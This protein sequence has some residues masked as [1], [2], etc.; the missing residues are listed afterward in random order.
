MVLTSGDWTLPPSHYQRCGIYYHHQHDFV[1]FVGFSGR[2]DY[3][4]CEFAIDESY[5]VDLMRPQMFR[6]V[7]CYCIAIKFIA[8]IK[9]Q[10]ILRRHTSGIDLHPHNTHTICVK[11]CF[12][13]VHECIVR[14]SLVF[15]FLS[16]VICIKLGAILMDFIAKCC[17]R[18][19]EIEATTRSD[20]AGPF[21]H[22]RKPQCVSHTIQSCVYNCSVLNNITFPINSLLIREYRWTMLFWTLKNQHTNKRREWMN[23]SK[24][25]CK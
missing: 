21:M 19:M 16:F 12:R 20:T 22:M 4:L 11:M 6:S 5:H 14:Y 7:L 25:N 2:F 10:A 24:C 1:C 8:V 23:E 3:F 15:S 18:W 17:R 13:V 9:K